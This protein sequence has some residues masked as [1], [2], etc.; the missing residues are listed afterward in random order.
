[1][2]DDQTLAIIAAIL[3]APELRTENPNDPSPGVR[4][5]VRAARLIVDEVQGS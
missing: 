5:V 3:L 2:R 1:M 4:R